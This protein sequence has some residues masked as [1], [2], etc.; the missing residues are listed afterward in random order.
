MWRLAL[1]IKHTHR[2]TL[3]KL[4]AMNKNIYKYSIYAARQIWPSYQVTHK[5]TSSKNNSN[6]NECTLT[7]YTYSI[8]LYS[9][10][11]LVYPIL[12]TYCVFGCSLPEIVDHDSMRN[13][14]CI[15]VWI[16]L[17]YIYQIYIFMCTPI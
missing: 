1:I 3:Y 2:H 11:Q 5:T 10:L 16:I 9:I 15:L 14:Y 12:C 6:Y 8:L 7:F 17:N 4:H 13:T